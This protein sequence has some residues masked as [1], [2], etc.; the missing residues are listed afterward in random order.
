MF[1]LTCRFFFS[2][3]D[4]TSNRTTSHAINHPCIQIKIYIYTNINTHTH[5]LS[6]STKTHERLVHSWE[7]IWLVYLNL[8]NSPQSL[9]RFYLCWQKHLNSPLSRAGELQGRGKD[10]FPRALK[11]GKLWRWA[12]RKDQGMGEFSR[13]SSGKVQRKSN[14]ILPSAHK[15][16]KRNMNCLCL[17]GVCFIKKKN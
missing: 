9:L 17:L 5:R 15:F 1:S 10:I 13:S 4:L 3:T 12:D 8:Q 11:E 7:K 14:T 6:L 2:P 16:R